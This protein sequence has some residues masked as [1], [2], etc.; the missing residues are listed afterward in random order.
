MKFSIEWL[1]EYVDTG[2]L[3]PEVLA[4]HLTMLGLEVDSVEPIFPELTKLQTAKIIKVE[5]HPDADKLNL[6]QVDTGDEVLSIV[7]GA[8]NV[9]EGMITAFAPVGT[10]MPGG[11][12]IKASKVR[13]IK[14]LGMLCSE[15]E[16]GLSESHNGIMELPADTAHGQTLRKALGIDDL[17]VEVD[18]TPNRPDC[19]SVI[20][21]AREVAGVTRTPLTRPVEEATLEHNNSNF[22]VDVEN[23]ELCPRY[24]AKLIENVKIAPSP[25]WLRKRLLSVGLR[26]INNVVDITN[27]VMMEYGQP[28]HAFDYDKISGKQ[29]MVRNPRNSETTFT[30]LDEEERNIDNSMLMIC[31]AEKP[32]AVAGV[33]GGLNSEVTES[34]TNILPR[35]QLWQT[36]FIKNAVVFIDYFYSCVCW[37]PYV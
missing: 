32:I 16:L 26:P 2:D 1:Q 36:H 9:Y 24:A 37:T 28:L 10:V 19:A 5:S 15:S 22:R 11:M 13:G 6:C 17:V 20:G 23:N 27:F 35:L 8:P 21:I 34:T 7:C 14:S 33:M 30:T 3:S 12:K 31:D 18:L 4:E 29:I 25:W